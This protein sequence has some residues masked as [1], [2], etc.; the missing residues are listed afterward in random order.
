M[1]IRKMRNIVA[2]GEGKILWKE[3]FWGDGIYTV[4]GTE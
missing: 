1:F 4:S 3:G 2:L